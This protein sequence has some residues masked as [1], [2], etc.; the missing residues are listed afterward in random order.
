MKKLILAVAVAGLFLA[1]CNNKATT[2]GS[3]GDSTAMYLKKITQIAMSS[4]SAFGKKD[5]AG[6]MKDYAANFVEYGSGSGKPISNLDTIK[7]GGVKLL[8]AFPDFSGDKLHA[9]AAD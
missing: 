6:S 2:T 7:A 9:T 3:A 1:S 5:V 4:D 8:D